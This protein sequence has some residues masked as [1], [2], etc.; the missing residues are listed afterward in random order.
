MGRCRDSSRYRGWINGRGS[1]RLRAGSRVRQ[2]VNLGLRLGVRV[3]LGIG[4]G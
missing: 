3:V 2:R 4:V 1:V